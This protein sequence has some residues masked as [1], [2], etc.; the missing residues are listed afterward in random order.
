[1]AL[2]LPRESSLTV[3]VFYPGNSL[4]HQ[5]SNWVGEHS[6]CD[7]QLRFPESAHE[8]RNA[9]QGTTI[10][11]VDSTDEPARATAVFVQLIV[12]SG[13]ECVS[14]YTEK[15]HAGLELFVRRRGAL[16]LLGP[17][18]DASWAGLFEAM[19]RCANQKSHFRFPTRQ[20][21][22]EDARMAAAWLPEDRLKGSPHNR[23]RKIA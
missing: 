1:M 22:E 2:Q 5:V 11:I 12:E 9:I 4:M 20:P 10:S 19:Q 14:V 16:L 18:S 17:M 8:I 15:M 6:A 3:A 23:F 13:P 7:F 21:A